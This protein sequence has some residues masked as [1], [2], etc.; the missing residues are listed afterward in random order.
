[1][2][3]LALDIAALKGGRPAVTPKLVANHRRVYRVYQEEGL[4]MRRR[5]RKRF[6]AEAR[7]P[8]VLPTRANQVWT[9]DFT[10]HSLASGR[11][12]RTLNPMDRFTREAPRIEVD[13]SRRGC[14]WYGWWTTS[15]KCGE[16]R[17]RFKWT[18]G[19]SSSAGR[20]ASGP[21]RTAWRCTSSSRASRAGMP[22]SKV[23]TGS[24]AMNA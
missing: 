20:W 9:M 24:P 2:A 19:R 21:T 14:A 16:C 17:K 18:T 7:A 8:F 11:K 4:A 3:Q 12:F 13:T 5:K 10:R 23:S 1:V 6:R 22:S 15:S